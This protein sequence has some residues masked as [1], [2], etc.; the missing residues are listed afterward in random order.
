MGNKESRTKLHGLI[1]KHIGE[2]IDSVTIP[3]SMDADASFVKVFLKSSST[4]NRRNSQNKRKRKRGERK[5]LRFCLF[6]ENKETLHAVSI[7]S[8]SLH[9][10]FKSSKKFAFAGTKDKRGV[11]SQW[12]TFD[13]GD[14]NDCVTASRNLSVNL[15]RSGK[16]Q[17]RAGNFSIVD[18]SLFLGDLRGN[19]FSLVLRDI[20]VSKELVE[21]ACRN[22]SNSG[23]INYFGLQR[24]GSGSVATYEIGKC[25]LMNDWKV[26][27]GKLFDCELFSDGNE[28]VQ[29][30]QEMTQILSQTH[31][32]VNNDNI[33]KMRWISKTI[34]S[35]RQI[36]GRI[37]QFFSHKIST[38]A[39]DSV[40]VMSTL[41]HDAF[42]GLPMHTRS[43]YLHAYQSY[44]WNLAASFRISQF[45]VGG[46]IVGDQIM[47][48]KT[49]DDV[50]TDNI[51]EITPEK[52]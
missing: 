14:S 9:L 11:T 37:A 51:V 40:L 35:K 7:L 12:I 22:L 30:R 32:T 52:I 49:H 13:A 36:E 17:V 18:N 21:E 5:Y 42:Q 28:M 43:L 39:A 3:N 20:N 48:E 33:E 23:F 34:P 41:C 16:N 47:V 19:H 4:S 2:T 10:G 31:V 27:V 46:L 45:G 50:V 29:I 24:F 6:K 44:I 15:S 38:A 1:R 25:I 8:H 26:V